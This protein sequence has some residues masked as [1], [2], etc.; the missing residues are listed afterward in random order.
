MFMPPPAIHKNQGT[1]TPRG[2][3]CQI[4]GP[5]RGG[6][7]SAPH[8]LNHIY[9]PHRVQETPGPSG[10]P[11]S[12]YR[13][14]AKASASFLRSAA[15]PITGCVFP[16]RDQPAKLLPSL[17]FLSK[18]GRGLS[19]SSDLTLLR[20]RKQRL[21]PV[22]PGASRLRGVY[23]FLLSRMGQRAGSRRNRCLD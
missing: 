13:G 12:F 21:S 7:E 1:I 18:P 23:H 5:V 10:K 3:H 20:G 14:W 11:A 6:C 8:T 15:G 2:A 22:S 9:N 19:N 16:L 17:H 4:L